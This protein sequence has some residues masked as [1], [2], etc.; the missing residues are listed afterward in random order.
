M[1]ADLPD[2]EGLAESF[3]ALGH[4]IRLAIVVHLSQAGESNVT[5]IHTALDI[6]QAT[7]SHHLRILRNAGLVT[8]ERDGKSSNY[9]SS[10]GSV[11]NFLKNLL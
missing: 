9:S 10:F 4:P 1:H 11:E 3:R 7:A 5:S 2:L 8:V 6:E